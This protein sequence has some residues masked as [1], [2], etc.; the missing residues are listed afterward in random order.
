M[1]LAID[2][3]YV[4][5]NRARI[6]RSLQRRGTQFDLT[7]IDQLGQER[8]KLQTGHDVAKSQLNEHSTTVGKLQRE[9][10]KDSKKIED[11]KEKSSRLKKEIQSHEKQLAEIAAKLDEKL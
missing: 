3:R 5:A 7:T 4:E 9:P 6:E 8:R 2:Y 10:T 11:L 1:A